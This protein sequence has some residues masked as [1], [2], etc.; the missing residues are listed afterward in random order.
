MTRAEHFAEEYFAGLVPQR[1][2]LLLELEEDARREDIPII[3][4]V[5]GSLLQL[6]ALSSGARDVLELGTATGYS[7]LYLA[8]ACAR[9]EG[10]LVTLESS[11]GLAER[12]RANFRR[13]G[14][15]KN[16]QVLE[17]PAVETLRAHQDRSYDLAFLD[18]DKEDYAPALEQ[19]RRLLRPGGLLVADNTSFPQAGEF[20]SAV[21]RDPSWQSVQLLSYLPGH[22]PEKD[23]I[24]LAVKVDH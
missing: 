12:A 16:V 18:I 23:G 19:C 10:T 3:G 7:G 13:A 4:P 17:G 1:D 22:S 6:L 21:Y 2:E 5:V 11:P 9:L 20:N 14:V 8:R 15:E 24:C